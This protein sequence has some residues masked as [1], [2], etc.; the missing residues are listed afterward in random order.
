MSITPNNSGERWVQQQCVIRLHVPSFY[1]Y[2]MS[3]YTAQEADSQS[4]EHQRRSKVLF[5]QHYP[6]K[7][8][9]FNLHSRQLFLLLE[10]TSPKELHL[11][12]TNLWHVIYILFHHSVPMQE[13]VSPLGSQ[14][15]QEYGDI[16]AW[17]QSFL[18]SNWW[19]TK[20]TVILLC[21]N[22]FTSLSC[23]CI[24]KV[25]LPCV[26]VF[27]TRMSMLY[28]LVRVSVIN[29]HFYPVFKPHFTLH[30]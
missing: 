23:K 15:K 28:V 4:K 9:A 17:L 20:F 12:W 18:K 10:H 19:G 2:K 26:S 30:F 11:Y 21:K 22:V 8:F 24:Y 3:L 5:Q 13:V 27:P 29:W 16:L 14:V 6:C 1:F 25:T 7:V